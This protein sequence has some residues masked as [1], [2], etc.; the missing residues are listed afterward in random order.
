LIEY[1]EG[2][3]VATDTGSHTTHEIKNAATVQIEKKDVKQIIKML[4]YITLNDGYIENN[5]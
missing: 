5:Y 3:T 4:E 1:D 2:K